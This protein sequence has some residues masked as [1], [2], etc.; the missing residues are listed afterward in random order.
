[1]EVVLFFRTVHVEKGLPNLAGHV[2]PTGIRNITG[3][4]G[5]GRVGSGRIR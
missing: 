2:R 1:M 4:V 5:L 3:R